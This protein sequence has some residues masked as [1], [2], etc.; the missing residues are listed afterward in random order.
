MEISDLSASALFRH[1]GHSLVALN[2][3]QTIHVFSRRQHH[4][5]HITRSRQNV[6][7]LAC[8]KGAKRQGN[9]SGVPVQ[10]SCLPHS[11][12]GLAPRSQ[13]SPL[14][15]QQHLENAVSC[16]VRIRIAGPALKW[17]HSVRSPPFPLAHGNGT[18]AKP[19]T[20][21]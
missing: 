7:T 9:G 6:K 3:T 18:T 20:A 1:W 4:C 16:K 21:Y 2:A 14:Q 13:S 17:C 10:L 11:R 12:P 15:Q 5:F 8:R 19:V